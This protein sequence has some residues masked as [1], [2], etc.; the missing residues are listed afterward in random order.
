MS[1]LVNVEGEVWSHWGIGLNAR[2]VD[3]EVL[4]FLWFVRADGGV[5]SVVWEVFDIFWL[6]LCLRSLLCR[7][8]V[9]MSLSLSWLP[10]SSSEPLSFI[11]AFLC[12]LDFLG[13][14]RNLLVT[15]IPEYDAVSICS[16]G[17]SKVG[18]PCDH[19]LF[20]DECFLLLRRFV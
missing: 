13:T 8:S 17:G 10:L 2:V 1:N 12:L 6:L 19:A 3:L 4:L 16:L 14:E 20:L 9:L 15:D 18:G 11:L 5:G 7:V